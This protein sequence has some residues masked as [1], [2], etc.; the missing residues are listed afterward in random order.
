[1]NLKLPKEELYKQYQ[2]I[3]LFKIGTMKQSLVGKKGVPQPPV[4]KAQEV[5]N[6]NKKEVK[7]RRDYVYTLKDFKKLLE[8]MNPSEIDY[9]QA[10]FGSDAL[11]GEL[12]TMIDH[13]IF[14][15][16]N[17]RLKMGLDPLDL[18]IIKQKEGKQEQVQEKKPA[19]KTNTAVTKK[20]G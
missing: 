5:L 9:Y 19:N 1:M 15:M 18:E 12:F 14:D 8:K 4:V 13:K 16:I 6:E 11:S 20:Y 7:V 3:L 17:T 10:V 2:Q